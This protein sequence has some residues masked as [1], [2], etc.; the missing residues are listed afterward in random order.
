MTAI[1]NGLVNDGLARK[2]ASADDARIVVVTPTAQGRRL[3]AR[4]RTR[5]IAKLEQLM[6]TFDADELDCLNRAAALMER[7]VATTQSTPS[8][9][10]RA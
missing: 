3:L 10:R 4:G 7:A 1:V 6:A 8:P 9:A 2:Q 5:R